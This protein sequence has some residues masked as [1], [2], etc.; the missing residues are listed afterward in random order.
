[1]VKPLFAALL[2]APVP[3]L[4]GQL[5]ECPGNFIP[6]PPDVGEACNNLAKQK[7]LLLAPG[8][9]GICHQAEQLPRFKLESFLG[10]G[11]EEFPQGLPMR[12]CPL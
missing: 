8:L 2:A 6:A 7:A 12:F 1:M 3:L 11:G 5:V 4:E 10:F 9:P